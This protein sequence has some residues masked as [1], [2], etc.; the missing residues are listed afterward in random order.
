MRKVRTTVDKSRTDKGKKR[1]RHKTEKNIL[2]IQRKDQR[3]SIEKKRQDKADICVYF[4]D[5]D[6]EATR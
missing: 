4:L 3:R 5:K 1:F 2:I 6:E